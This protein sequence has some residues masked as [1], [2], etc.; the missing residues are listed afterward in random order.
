MDLDTR[1]KRSKFISESVKVREN[2]H[3]AS[4]VETLMVIK[5]KCSSLYG[6]MLWDLGG[7][8][9]EQVFK[10]WNTCV[11]L[12]WN[13]PR[14]THTY[15]VDQL[16]SCGLS[17]LKSDVMSRYKG[18]LSSLQQ[19]PSTEVSTLANMMSRDVR[20]VTGRNVK[21]LE[22]QT[23]VDCMSVSKTLFKNTLLANI[24]N[25]PESDLWRVK[26]LGKLLETR[27]EYYYWGYDEEMSNISDIINSLCIT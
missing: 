7:Q 12:T 9:T 13:V 25:P 16:L 11:K 14:Q 4:P 27:G 6:S 3:F 10:A 2:F 23:G 21:Y 15:F 17:S 22:D 1:M 24:V 8:S 18:Y 19:S 26:L 5:R 20:S